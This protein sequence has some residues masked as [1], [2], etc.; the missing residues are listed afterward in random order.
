MRPILSS[1]L[2]A[3]L[4]SACAFVAP[5]TVERLASLDPLTTDPAG[6]ELVLILPKGLSVTP[7]SAKLDFGAER[8]T[9]VRKGTFQLRDEPITD[10]ITVPPDATARRY[11]LTTAD[12]QKM[13]DLQAEIAGWK[14]DGKAKGMLAV[15]VGGC[16]IGDGPAEDA[17]G[18]VLIR[19]AAGEPL[20]PLVSNAN[21][22]EL[23]G[24]KAFGAI[25][26]CTGAE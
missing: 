15:G 8:G 4:L 18:S 5:S 9:E 13:R 19:L 24:P 17:T 14:R 10:S 22:S 23:L 6:I 26:P 20:L 2:A 21:L 3:L 1:C 25:Q 7:G 11:S 16:A 12:A